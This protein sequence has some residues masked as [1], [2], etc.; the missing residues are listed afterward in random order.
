MSVTC[1]LQEVAGLG[2]G[3]LPLWCLLLTVASVRELPV[4]VVDGYAGG[5]Y[6]RPPL[7]VTARSAL[8]AAAPPPGALPS[9]CRCTGPFVGRRGGGTPALLECFS[10][11]VRV[12]YQVG[13]SV[14][15]IRGVLRHFQAG[16]G[17]SELVV[18]H[19]VAVARPRFDDGQGIQEWKW[20]SWY[21][22]H[23]QS[24]LPIAPLETAWGHMGTFGGLRSGAFTHRLKVPAIAMDWEEDP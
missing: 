24:W 19:C 17:G 8:A 9:G 4:F 14:R 7:L 11:G 15:L 21:R 10:G 20:L 22:I 6:L 3:S 12:V 5:S 18:R 23:F 1:W 13:T 2:A 16:R